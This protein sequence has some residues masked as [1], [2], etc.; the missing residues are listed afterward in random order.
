MNPGA[1][2]GLLYI[3]LA[4]GLIELWRRGYLTTWTDQALG[5]VS[6]DTTKTKTSFTKWPWS[7]GV[8]GG[9]GTW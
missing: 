1:Q 8:Q 7:S 4:V 6:G 5:A 3:V 2:A 9:G